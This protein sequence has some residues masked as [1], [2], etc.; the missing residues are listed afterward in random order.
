MSLNTM[1]FYCSRVTSPSSNKTRSS[2]Y[3]TGRHRLQDQL[4]IVV[5]ADFLTK[6]I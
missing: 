4:A 5:K 2:T 6:P 1:Y 3:S